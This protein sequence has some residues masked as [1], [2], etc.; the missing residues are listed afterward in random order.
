[1]TTTKI[2]C[3]NR[4]E[5]PSSFFL[6]P[7]GLYTQGDERDVRLTWTPFR[8]IS[9]ARTPDGRGWA[10]IIE[11][12]N[13]DGE[14]SEV[15][16]TSVELLG[17]GSAGLK[18]LADA[19]LEVCPGAEDTVVSFIRASR[20]R[21]RD[22]L[23][24]SGGWVEGRPLYVTPKKVLGN[25][26]DERILYRPEA[27]SPTEASMV[28]RG[29]LVDWR[30]NVAALAKG[31][32][33]LIFCLA[34]SFT[35]I[36]LRL[37]GLDGGGFHFFGRSSRGKTTLLQIGSSVHGCGSD[38]GSRGAS[39]VRRWNITGNAVEALGAAHND[40]VLVLD[41]IGTFAGPD[42]DAL[43][44]NLTG[45][46]GK[47]AMT[48][49]R[50]LRTQRTW[51]CS[52]LSS[53]E[54]SYLAK[55]SASGRQ[56]M[57]GQLIR[58]IDIAIGD[59]PFHNTKGMSPADFANTIKKA[60]STYY[61][62]AGSAFI[63][64]LIGFLA[65]DADE[66]RDAL[67]Q[68]LED[69]TEKLTPKGLQ[70]EQARAIRRFALVLLAGE[71]A[72][73]F[74]V[75]PFEDAEILEAVT[76]AR[77]SWLSAFD[78][79]SDVERGIQALQ[80]FIIRNHGSFPNIRNPNARVSNS[81]AFYNSDQE[82]YLFNDEQLKAAAGECDPKELVKELRAKK[83]LVTHEGGRLKVKQK[84]ASMKGKWV[85]FYA[86]RSQIV[87]HET[88][89]SGANEKHTT[90]ELPEAADQEMVEFEMV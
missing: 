80:N 68:A 86:V 72:I 82:L 54:V 43:I 71:L 49:K 1:M 76:F 47:V 22:L 8:V 61:G 60:C 88:K 28:A 75:L 73:Q 85:R 32:P 64:D 31:N 5:F 14:V 30:E 34:A 19:G 63:E 70:P 74:G 62:T 35:G 58:M 57:A 44:Y 65:D 87:S 66:V 40:G 3:E 6:E 81:K 9:R 90:E 21:Q 41:E 48:S 2:D 45:G 11:V 15:P 38:P 7:D 25:P 37:L 56:I 23:V 39:Y 52:I 42:I 36:L 59:S 16:V 24:Q 69:F 12:E 10:F 67:G 13:L 79:I 33:L 27:N 18:H 20:P 51:L 26:G 46:Q 55:A 4:G 89:E 53:G 77:D 83:L 84:L 78:N 29:T 17:K 50:A